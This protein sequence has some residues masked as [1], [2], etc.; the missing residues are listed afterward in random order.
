MTIDLQNR[1]AVVTGAGSGIGRAIALR[2]A[3]AGASV[4][5]FEL[6]HETG[7]Q[8]VETIRAAGGRAETVICDVADADSVRAA[9]EPIKRLDIL[10][11]NAGVAHVGNVEKTTPEDFDRIYRINVK[12]VYHCLHFGVANILA[13]GEGGGGGRRRHSQHGLSRGE[14]RHSRPLCLLHEQGRGHGH[15]LVRGARLRG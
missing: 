4:M 11:N 10:V 14:G 5:V 8:T 2:L 3:G 1:T 12:G 6:T 7:E 15:D 13:Q 9:F